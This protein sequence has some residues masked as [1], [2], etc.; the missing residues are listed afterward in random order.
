[1]HRGENMLKQKERK[2]FMKKI[3][4]MIIPM[5]L[6]NSAAYGMKRPHPGEQ[7]VLANTSGPLGKKREINTEQ[8]SIFTD[9]LKRGIIFQSLSIQMNLEYKLPREQLVQLRDAYMQHGKVDDPTYGPLLDQLHMAFM[10]NIYAPRGKQKIGGPQMKI[11]DD[12]IVFE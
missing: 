10:N 5:V 9:E 12:Q 7:N 2:L 4:A 3:M 11:V 1:M 8:P 6:I